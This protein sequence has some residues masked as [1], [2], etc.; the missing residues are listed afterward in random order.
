MTPVRWL[1]VVAVAVAL[2]SAVLAAPPGLPSAATRLAA[3]ARIGAA[4]DDHP[5]VAAIAQRGWLQ[6]DERHAVLAP[7]WPMD[8][9]WAAIDALGGDRLR[10]HGALRYL[11]IGAAARLS[12]Q[13]SAGPAADEVRTAQLDARSALLVGWVKVLAEPAVAARR[14]DDRAERTGALDLLARARDGMPGVQ[15][16]H[17]AWALAEAS[18]ADAPNC[19]DALAILAAARQPGQQA[20]RLA[21]AERADAA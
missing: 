10:A 4:Y 9:A 13:V 19:A 17:L 14:R 16:A 3:E 11:L 2:P 7:G 1:L 8:R 12:P 15:A 5:L 6:A 18:A 20:V 21:A